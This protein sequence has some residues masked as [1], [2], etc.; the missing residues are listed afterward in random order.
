MLLTCR[1]MQDLLHSDQ[2]YLP[3]AWHILPA[4]YRIDYPDHYEH[5]S[6]S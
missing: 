2:Y 1:S 3:C 6:D 4:F 5:R